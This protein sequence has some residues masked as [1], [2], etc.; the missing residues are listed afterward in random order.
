KVGD[1][2]I[3]GVGAQLGL[4]A[5]GNVASVGIGLC[6][7]GPRCLKA[8]AAEAFLRGKPAAPDNVN[9]AARLAM[10]ASQPI[11]DDRGPADYKRAMVRV[12]AV[13]ALQRALGRAQGGAR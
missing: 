1:Y 7:V 12:L 6:N 9:E 8:T 11:T 4:G 5:G 3:V 13:R 10:E 2:A